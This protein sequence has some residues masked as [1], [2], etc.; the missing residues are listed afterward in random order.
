MNK[1]EGK[2]TRAI[3][4]KVQVELSRDLQSAANKLKP[5]MYMGRRSDVNIIAN[6]L[7]YG[8][9][10]INDINK[11]HKEYLGM[12][13]EIVLTN[14][15]LLMLGACGYG[16]KHDETYLGLIKSTVSDETATKK[17]LNLKGWV[18]H[19]IESP[20][21][22]TF[23]AISTGGDGFVFDGSAR[24]RYFIWDFE[25]DSFKTKG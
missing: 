16:P 3:F 24:C 13:K 5:L 20:R 15:S 2:L 12:E 17:A 4:K 7:A 22:M 21:C 23:I 8:V 9:I 14:L 1:L 19:H 10:D 6:L 25:K 18:T 11:L